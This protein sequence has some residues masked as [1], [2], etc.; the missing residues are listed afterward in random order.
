M[1][2]KNKTKKKKKR[3]GKERTKLKKSTEE[4]V[5]TLRNVRLLGQTADLDKLQP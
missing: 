4:D 5:S 3:G 2:T 1:T